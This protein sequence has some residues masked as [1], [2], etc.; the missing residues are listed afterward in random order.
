MTCIEEKVS[1]GLVSGF[2]NVYKY[3]E[4]KNMVIFEPFA[5][6]RLSMSDEQCGIL[7][8]MVKNLL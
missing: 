3:H 2:N 5:W 1:S 8:E 4:A 7:A 6:M